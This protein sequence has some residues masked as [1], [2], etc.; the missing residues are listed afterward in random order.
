[1]GVKVSGWRIGL[2]VWENG[3]SRGRGWRMGSGIVCVGKMGTVGVRVGDLEWDCGP[4]EVMR[5]WG[6]GDKGR[7]GRR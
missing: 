6:V 7:D 3:N 4:R 1:M 2:W 5:M